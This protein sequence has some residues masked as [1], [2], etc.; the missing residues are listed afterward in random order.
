ML[1]RKLGLMFSGQ[2][3]QVRELGKDFYENFESV[4]SLYDAH[5]DIRDMAFYAD[6]EEIAK[7]QNT[8]RILL[9]FQVAMVDLL[10]EYKID[11]HASMGMS[12]GEYGALYSADVLNKEQVIDVIQKRADSMAKCSSSLSLSSYAVLNNDFSWL[13]EHDGQGYYISNINSSTQQIITGE[14]L[15]DVLET[16]TQLEYK[17]TIKLDVSGGFHSPY[18]QETQSLLSEL[19]AKTQ[20]KDPAFPI[21]FNFGHSDMDIKERM[22][23]QVS[24]KINVHNSLVQID[25]YCDVLIEIGAN[26]V[27]EN[28]MRKIN[29]KKEVSKLQTIEDFEKV[30]VS[31]GK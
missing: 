6:E 30:R 12:L 24:N 18:M 14:N 2:G 9:L 7:T 27:L 28:L 22:A 11:F 17:K 4:K 13:E 20:F 31:L 8:Q 16:L 26:K 19:F 3:S 23:K 29:K 5:P 21:F 15:Q 1:E 25:E 10:K